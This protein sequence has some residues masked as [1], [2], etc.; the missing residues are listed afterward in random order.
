MMVVTVFAFQ[1]NAQNMPGSKVPKEAKMAF[2]KAHPAV[3]NVTW[4]FERGNFEANWRVAGFDHSELY[5]RK[6][7]FAGSEIDINPSQLPVS[8]NE[9]M[10]K[11]YRIKAKEA[12]VNEDANHVKTYEVDAKG[13]AYIFDSK[14]KF[15]K[16]GE[17]D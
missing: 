9:Y 2:E 3:K 15:L 12:S 8:V 13:K 1:V 11:H 14:G 7:V 5:T 4:E 10:L 6:G 16:V 17:D